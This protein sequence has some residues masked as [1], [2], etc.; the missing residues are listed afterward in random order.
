MLFY[1]IVIF[2]Y[3]EIDLTIS[4][5]SIMQFIFYNNLPNEK[6]FNLV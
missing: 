5:K 1:I 3:I 6:E 4:S 2:F